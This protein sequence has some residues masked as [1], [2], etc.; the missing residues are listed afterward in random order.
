MPSSRSHGYVRHDD[1]R[2]ESHQNSRGKSHHHHHRSYKPPE[3]EMMRNKTARK[4]CH[5]KADRH[6]SN[7]TH[8]WE[9]TRLPVSKENN[10]PPERTDHDDRDMNGCHPSTKDTSNSSN[11]SI[12]E[13]YV[14]VRAQ[15]S[16]GTATVTSSTYFSD[17]TDRNNDSKWQSSSNKWYQKRF[18]I[19]AG[20][21]G[22]YK[23]ATNSVILSQD[24]IGSGTLNGTYSEGDEDFLRTK[25]QIAYL[26]ILLTSIQ[27]L[28]LMLQL[29]MCGVAPLDVNPMVGPFPDAFS[30]FGGKNAYLM[31][32]ENEWWRLVTPA[33]LHVGAL[34]LLANAFCQLETVAFFE[35]EWGSTRWFIIYLL[36]SAG[37]TVFSSYF[38]PFTI[39]VGSSSALMG[40]YGAKLAQV[41]SHTCCHVNKGQDDVI[42]LGHL[43]GILC[44]LTLV[45]LLSSFT[46]I[47]WSGHVGGLTIGFLSG[48]FM[49]C[50][51]IQNRCLQFLWG[52]LGFI[53]MCAAMAT[54]MYFFI[55]TAELNEEMADACQY[56]RNLFTED[57]ECGCMATS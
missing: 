13:S 15:L 25:Q 21:F 3:M 9:E 2:D 41:M 54:V 18:R 47:D 23:T 28:I 4:E 30:L 1:W 57:Y 40:M 43:S 36:S 33:F 44:G 56:F 39:A 29:T 48:M 32:N 42:R 19:S 11:S 14:Q 34:H 6:N 35:R 51:P 31:L 7:S 38:D 52:A 46:Y 22:I 12:D 24:T 8:D 20:T 17:Q 26:S 45:S 27:I 10:T 49:F 5:F 37:S 16:P 53:G 50:K 55:T